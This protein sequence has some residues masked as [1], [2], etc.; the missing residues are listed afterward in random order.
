MEAGDDLLGLVRKDGSVAAVQTPDE[1][2]VILA[3]LA[4]QEIA[5]LQVLGIN[6]LKS[7]SPMPSAL[8]GD[9]IESSAVVDRLFTVITTGHQ[10]KVD[11][12][13]T[14]RVVWL[15]RTE[16]YVMSA[17]TSRPTLRLVLA[18]GQG[19]DLTEPAKTKRIAVTISARP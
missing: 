6:S 10:V 14:G 2:Q 17:G 3:R 9:T 12:Q 11:L 18:S 5:V 15:P 4:G 1:I 16:P 7:F 19:L 13:R 8:T